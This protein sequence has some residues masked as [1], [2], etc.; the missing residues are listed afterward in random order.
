MSVTLDLARDGDE[1]AVDETAVNG[2]EI[3]NLGT[4][5]GLVASMAVDDVDSKMVTVNG[6]EMLLEDWSDE[7]G[8]YFVGLLNVNGELL[9]I[10][11]EISPSAVMDAARDLLQ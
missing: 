8:A 7:Y 10:R 6:T 2:S 1:F 4:F 3:Y 11:S 5:D 9:E